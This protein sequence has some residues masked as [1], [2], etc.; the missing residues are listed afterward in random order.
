M[1]FLFFVI[2]LAMNPTTAAFIFF[3]SFYSL[4]NEKTRLD[5]QDIAVQLP[6]VACN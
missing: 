3:I 6:T 1:I 4:K 5:T 2:D